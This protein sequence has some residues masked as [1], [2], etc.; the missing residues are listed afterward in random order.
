MA[1]DASPT[2]SVRFCVPTDR[3]RA[4]ERLT[5]PGRRAIARR[6]ILE[7]SFH[8]AAT[9]TPSGRRSRPSPSR[10]GTL[11]G[12]VERQIYAAGERRD[13]PI[14]NILPASKIPIFETETT[15]MYAEQNAL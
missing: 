14:P 12:G 13:G 5:S 3:P 6:V 9:R 1:L 7:R 15:L 2:I 8:V 10:R 11:A 4:A